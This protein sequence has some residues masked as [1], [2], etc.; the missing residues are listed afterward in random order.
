MVSIGANIETAI[1]SKDKIR[2]NAIVEAGVWIDQIGLIV[3]ALEISREG[4]FV[5]LPLPSVE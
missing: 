3:S 2:K 5:G 4:Y 1:N